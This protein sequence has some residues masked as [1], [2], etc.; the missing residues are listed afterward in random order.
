M[1]IQAPEV[2]RSSIRVAF[3][4]TI[5]VGL[6]YLVISVGVY[7]IVTQ[8]LTSQIDAQ[9]SGALHSFS[10]QQIPPGGDLPGLPRPPDRQ[11]DAPFLRWLVLED[12]TVVTGSSGAPLP[13]ALRT[14]DGAATATIG[15]SPFRLL[16]T[17]VGDQRLIVGQTMSSVT[18]A[19]DTIF[20]AELIV[21]PILLALVFLGAVAIGRRVAAPIEQ[22][23]LRQ[24]EFTADASHELRT[25]LAV[26]EAQ[27]SL[28][29]AQPRDEAWYRRGFE[30]VDAESRRMRKLVEDLLWLARFDATGSHASADLVDVGVLAAQAVDRFAAV[31]E[32]R[33]LAL[34][35]RVAAGGQ[36][37]KAPPEWLDRLLGVLLDNACKYAPEGGSVVVVVDDD[38]GRVRVRVDDSGP[39]IPEAERGRIFDRF[40]RATGSGGGAGLGL[41]IG[42]AIARATGGR[43]RIGASEVGGASLAVSWPRAMPAARSA[44]GGAA[45]T[46]DQAAG[47][48]RVPSAA[49]D[50]VPRPGE[51]AVAP[52]DTAATPRP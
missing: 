17:A 13:A 15:A 35:L 49:A 22:A 11:F 23:R 31:A 47:S 33:R 9:L 27:T 40:H 50:A 24:L 26:I 20:Q 10:G 34:Q 42:D 2:S 41:A 46:V 14:L 19:Q 48:V 44:A 25:P 5:V 21:A 3:G 51:A 28:A 12:G 45:A 29:L 39:G 52:P 36:V 43:W 4:S 38:G 16:G 32:T 30:R 1:S 7:A 8:N 37:V 18:D 6:L